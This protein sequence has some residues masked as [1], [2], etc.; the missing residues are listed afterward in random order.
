MVHPL[1]GTVEPSQDLFEHFAQHTR[2]P[3]LLQAIVILLG[4]LSVIAGKFRS[5]C[6]EIF[7]PVVIVILI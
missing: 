3:V 6:M 2:L 7:W 5:T 4:G 1:P